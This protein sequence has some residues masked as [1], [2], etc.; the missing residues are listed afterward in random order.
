MKESTKNAVA[1]ALYYL[2]LLIMIV[3][4]LMVVFQFGM[5]KGMADAYKTQLKKQIEM[6]EEEKQESM[7]RQILEEKQ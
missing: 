2:F 5:A 6:L 3:G 1:S 4:C 7:I